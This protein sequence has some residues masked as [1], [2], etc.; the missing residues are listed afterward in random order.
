MG[1]AKFFHGK[2]VVG[3]G[4]Q[5]AGEGLVRLR[6]VETPRRREI[7]FGMELL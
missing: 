1:V 2:Y 5:L 6:L 3:A 4:D 7:Q